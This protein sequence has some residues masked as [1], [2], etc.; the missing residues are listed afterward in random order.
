MTALP[1]APPDPPSPRAPFVIAGLGA[2]SGVLSYFFFTQFYLYGG[3]AAPGLCFGIA[4]ITA[5]RYLQIKSKFE[6]GM[7]LVLSVLGWMLAQ[8]GATSIHS[9]FSDPSGLTLDESQPN[10]VDWFYPYRLA[11]SGL[12]AGLVWS[13]SIAMAVSIADKTFRNFFNWAKIVLIGAAAGLILQFATTNFLWPPV[14]GPGFFAT[15]V[16][17]QAAVA[18]CIGFVAAGSHSRSITD[19]F[20]PPDQGAKRSSAIRN[21]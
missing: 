17:W 13:L 14:S 1:P 7:L 9:L 20:P 21:P 15:M 4:L 10:P 12:F 2:A 6:L 16:A 19:A 8:D 18:A 3:F 11:I 5:G